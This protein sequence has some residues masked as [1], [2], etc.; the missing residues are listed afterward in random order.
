MRSFG[1][2]RCIIVLFLSI[3]PLR[4][5]IWARHVAIGVITQAKASGTH[6]V[7]LAAMVPTK[8]ALV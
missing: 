8:R 3:I 7:A 2:S 6:A 5:I 1:S 4:A